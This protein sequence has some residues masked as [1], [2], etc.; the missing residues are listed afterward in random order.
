MQ[1]RDVKPASQEISFVRR[2][3]SQSKTALNA[4]VSTLLVLLVYS[5]FPRN[6]REKALF[7]EK[8]TEKREDGDSVLP[9]LR[10]DEKKS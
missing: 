1:Q 6:T 3:I 8:K 7:W 5:S 2:T 9:F 4:R 10:N